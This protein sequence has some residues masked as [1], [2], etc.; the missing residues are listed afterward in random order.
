M[1]SI[2]RIQFLELMCA[3]L[4][5][6]SIIC[7]QDTA[8][9]AAGDYQRQTTGTISRLRLLWMNQAFV[10]AQDS[11]GTVLIKKCKGAFAI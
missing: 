7:L 10:F 3:V 9:A 1:Q 2:C 5:C 8:Q 4:P 11:T 6:L